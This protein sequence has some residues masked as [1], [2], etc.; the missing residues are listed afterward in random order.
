MNLIPIQYH[1]RKYPIG[2]KPK[3]TEVA[4]NFDVSSVKC[5]MP[6]SLHTEYSFAARRFD[7]P[8]LKKLP[9]LRN[10]C[11][12]GIP[13][14]WY[15]EKWASEFADFV[16]ELTSKNIFPKIVEIHP[17]FNDYCPSF[18]RFIEI[19]TVFEDK[20]LSLKP[21]TK[22]LI[23]NRY[24]SQYRGGKFLL[25]SNV[26]FN[27]LAEAI[28][29]SSCELRMILDVPQVFTRHFGPKTKTSHDIVSTFAPLKNCRAYI[30]GIHLWGKRRSDSGRWVSHSGNLNTYFNGDSSVK[31][32]FLNELAQLFDDPVNRYFVPEVN[33]SDSDLHSIIDD[34]L[35]VGFHFV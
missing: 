26:D 28:E 31:K 30:A 13:Q 1:K 10:S 5:D 32:V 17:P 22:I 3:L 35:S 7:S 24:G 6:Y 16:V 21:D 15:N 23:E 34:L 19:Y 8:L 4:G 18:N 14:L 29:M 12:H 9:T 2:I 25:S 11:K 27:E 33:S 20:L